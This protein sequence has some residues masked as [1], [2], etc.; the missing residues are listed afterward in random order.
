M[1]KLEDLQA[2]PESYPSGSIF[3]NEGI[4]LYELVKKYKPK[5]IIEVGTRF[6]CSTQFMAL[7]CKEN[8]YGVIHTYDIED[9]Y[10]QKNEDLEPFIIRHLISYFDAPNKKCD[11]LFEDGAHTTG[12]TKK[13]LEE[14]T[15]KV[16]AVHDYEH[17]DCL[18]TVKEEALS[19]LGEPTEIH[20]VVPSD[21]GLGI[22][23]NK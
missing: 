7:A 6:G 12:F 2:Y 11:L 13:V 20:F 16:C 15:F 17:W 18:I 14:T 10:I 3:R 19:V 23:I 4:K 1:T 22:W 21:C 8:G 5:K 9:H